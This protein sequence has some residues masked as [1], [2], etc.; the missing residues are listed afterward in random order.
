M[1]ERV[2]IE[3]EWRRR[4]FTRREAVAAGFSDARLRGRDLDAPFRGVRV[5]PGELSLEGRCRAYFAL[6]RP[7]QAVGGATALALA[8]LPVPLRLRRPELEI[9]VPLGAHRPK[10]RG[11]VAARIRP[12]LWRELDAWPFPVLHP[13]VAWLML[14][15]RLRQ[16]ETVV[17]ADALLAESDSYPGIALPRPILRPESLRAAVEAFGSAPGAPMLRAAVEVARAGSASPM[18]TLARL[19]IVRAGFAE[20]E[21]N[22]EIRESG[23]LLAV[24]D[25]V[26]R[27]ERV[28]VEYQGDHHRTDELQF[29]RDIARRRRLAAAGW[30]VIEATA[31]DLRRGA[32]ELLADLRRAL[33]GLPQS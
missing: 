2:A 6:P 24:G 27:A 13:V 16:D 17:L 11:V 3:D 29:R 28:V 33:A 25:L 22:A 8:G 5:A 20:P 1:G 9:A 31:D 15:R 23:R 14:G 30:T 32:V 12:G 21:L 10:S 26:Y 19:A 4:P 18:E 7:G